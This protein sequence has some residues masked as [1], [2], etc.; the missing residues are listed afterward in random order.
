[1]KNSTILIGALMLFNLL[2]L[3]TNHIRQNKIDSLS[4]QVLLLEEDRYWNNKVDDII[5]NA[6][7]IHNDINLPAN[8]GISLVV[9]ITDRGCTSCLS[10]ETSNLNELYKNYSESL[11]VYLIGNDEAS[12][13]GN[14][15][16]YDAKFP[17]KYIKADQSILDI[18]FDF[19]STVIALLIDG[20]GMIQDI[21]LSESG[22]P[23]KS[24]QFFQRMQS[25]FNS[26]NLN[27]SN[28]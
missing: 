17:T 2:L 19:F 26:P 12:L 22:N 9:F 10:F 23:K 14:L 13:K 5:G 28:I 6:S 21:Y 11:S 24:K 15:I 3:Y 18:D 25:L 7:V 20:N 16:L 1:M 8:S 4:S 27:N